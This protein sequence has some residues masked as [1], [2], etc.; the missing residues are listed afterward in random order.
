[1]HRRVYD[2]L[3]NRPKILK[4]SVNLHSANGTRL[5]VDGCVNAHFRIGGTEVSIT[6]QNSPQSV[7]F[8]GERMGWPILSPPSQFPLPIISKIIMELLFLCINL[9]SRN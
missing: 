8:S 6:G 4:K 3:K 7:F 9:K 1:M 5:Q 2:N